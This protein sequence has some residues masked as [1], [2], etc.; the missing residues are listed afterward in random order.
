MSGRYESG[1]MMP[2]VTI[3]QHWIEAQRIIGEIYEGRAENLHYDGDRLVVT[4]DD[5]VGM[6]TLKLL[7]KTDGRGVVQNMNILHFPP[8]GDEVNY[9][10]LNTGE[11][12]R[13]IADSEFQIKRNKLRLATL[14]SRVSINSISA[15]EHETFERIAAF[16][17]VQEDSRINPL[18][19]H[20]GYNAL[21]QKQLT[22]APHSTTN[23]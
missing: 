8:Y 21:F 22:A 19:R 15:E 3:E 13:H 16:T 18:Y 1:F 14:L 7:R 9:S 10:I 11:V 4:C 2:P 6:H 17:P 23:D 20:D 5:A 12:I